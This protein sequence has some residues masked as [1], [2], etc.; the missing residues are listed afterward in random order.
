MWLCVVDFGG[1]C[2]CWIGWIVVG[3]GSG[4]WW[5]CYEV[6]VVE[7]VWIGDCEVCGDVVVV[8]VFVCVV[9][10]VWFV[11]ERFVY[12]VCWCDVVFECDYCVGVV[13]WWF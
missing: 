1:D 13:G 5:D 7:I 2:V 10:C 9:V 6:D 3:V 4:Y 11:V 12:G 8:G